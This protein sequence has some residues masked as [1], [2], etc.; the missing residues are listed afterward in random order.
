MENILGSTEL[1]VEKKHTA[2]NIGSGNVE[3]LAT[4]V[5]IALLENAASQ[6]VIPL[7]KEDETTVG[8]FISVSHLAPTPEN[9]KVFAFS[10]LIDIS[11]NQKEFTFQLEAYD[12]TGLIAKGE[13]KRIKLKKDKFKQKSKNKLFS[14]A[15][16]SAPVPFNM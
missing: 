5:L 10:K 7:L 6:S 12:E 13:H 15:R 14:D 9:L 8:S 11:P 2:V 16:N 3:V 4:P 1:T